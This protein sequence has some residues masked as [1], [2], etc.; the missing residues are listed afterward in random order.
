MP[1]HKKNLTNKTQPQVPRNKKQPRKILLLTALT[2][3]VLSLVIGISFWKGNSPNSKLITA[4]VSKP[5]NDELNSVQKAAYVPNNL[6]P[7]SPSSQKKEVS[8]GLDFSQ[9]KGEF[10]GTLIVP[11][12]KPAEM[13][14][15]QVR[16]M[17]ELREGDKIRMSGEIIG[18]ITRAEPF[19][20]KPDNP[21]DPPPPP[22]AVYSRVIGTAKRVVDTLLYLHTKDETIKTTPEHPF[23]VEGKGWVEA[24]RLKN[25]DLIKTQAG[26]PIAVEF[27]ELRQERTTVHNLRVEDTETFYVGEGK[28]LVHNGGPCVPE[29]T[30]FFR[31]GNSLTARTIDVKIKDGLVQPTHGI[32]LNTTAEGLE[33]FGGAHRI[34]FIP[35]ELQIIQRG[36]AGHFEIVPKEAMP[37]ERFQELLNQVRLVAPQ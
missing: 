36:K 30:I 26:S 1:K 7:T 21:S 6:K 23:Y 19:I 22:G 27:T 35:D 17:H 20:P 5:A 13:I 4:A 25:G 33:R 2:L 3:T 31:G 16:L 29:G 18:L 32:S 8:L 15:G 14:N 12:N 10:T 24:G 34:D 9:G 11:A 28:L 37:L